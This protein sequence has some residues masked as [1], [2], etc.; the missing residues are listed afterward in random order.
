MI[1]VG[2]R[3]SWPPHEGWM[4]RDFVAREE[5]IPLIGR[6]LEVYRAG[7]QPGMRLREFIKSVGFE[8]FKGKVLSS[9]AEKA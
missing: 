4:L 9:E 2:G 1:F 3:G 8:E 6:I 5:V 7:A